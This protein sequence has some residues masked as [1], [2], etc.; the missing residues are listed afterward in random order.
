MRVPLQAV[1]GKLTLE[2]ISLSVFASGLY[3]VI[4]IRRRRSRKQIL[5]ECIARKI[6]ALGSYTWS[7]LLNTGGE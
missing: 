3:N 4:L 2:Y 7:T 1:Q 6:F 5:L